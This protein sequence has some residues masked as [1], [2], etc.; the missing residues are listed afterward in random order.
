MANHGTTT[1]A[2]DQPSGWRVQCQAGQ[3]HSV[4]SRPGCRAK[5]KRAA[6]TVIVH[7]VGKCGSH[8][9]E[10]GHCITLM[11]VRI[12]NGRRSPTV[13]LRLPSKKSQSV[14]FSP[15]DQALALDTGPPP[16]A[17]GTRTRASPNTPAAGGL[18]RSQPPCS[19]SPAWSPRLQ[20]TTTPP[21]PTP[22]PVH[23]NGP[24]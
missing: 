22:T 21:S 15:N 13:G 6:G 9:A 14:A 12:R 18:G 16:Y 11:L 1:P 19:R 20:P 8:G 5:A 2:Q 10:T 7:A 3:C 23:A 4:I 17:A 24:T